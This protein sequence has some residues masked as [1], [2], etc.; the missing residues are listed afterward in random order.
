M[1]FLFYPIIADNVFYGVIISGKDKRDWKETDRAVIEHAATVYAIERLKSD[2]I[3]QTQIKLRGDFLEEILHRNFRSRSAAIE[4][5]KKFGFDLSLPHTVI[6]LKLSPPCI[7]NSPAVEKTG[8]LYTV[9]A[10]VLKREQR[11]FIMKERLDAVTVLLQAEASECRDIAEIIHTGWSANDTGARVI[12]GLGRTYDEVSRLN[13]SADEAVCAADLHDL[14]LQ[15]KEIV[16]YDELSTFHLLLQVK[17]AGGNLAVF[18]NSILGNLLLQHG[19]QGIDFIKTLTA[20][21]KHN[22]NTQAAAEELFIHRHTLTY[23]LNQIEQKCHC[24]L[25][26]ADERLKLQ[27]AVAAYRLEQHLINPI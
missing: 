12:I 5:G 23:R 14:P 17:D 26:S 20:Y 25:N 11:Q 15:E 18:Y 2:A 8:Q 19:G 9:V 4:H 3:E 24:D 13:E 27:L 1:R 7:G 16:H 6:H 21:F 22:F 10:N